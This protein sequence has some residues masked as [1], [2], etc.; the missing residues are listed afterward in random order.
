MQKKILLPLLFT[1]PALP[2]LAD[3]GLNA[4]AAG[5]W[6][7]DAANSDF[8][9]DENGNVNA[10]IANGLVSQTVSG[11]PYGN[12]K[13][14]L[15]GAINCKVEVTGSNVKMGE[16]GAFEI[17]GTSTDNTI[18]IQISSADKT[19]NFGFG[20]C[21]L[22]LVEDYSAYADEME[23]KLTS[24]ALE[25]VSANVAAKLPDTA[26]SLATQK[27]GVEK[28]LT[29]IEAI[30]D[31]LRTGFPADDTKIYEVSQLVQLYNDYI[32]NKGLEEK[33][34]GYETAVQDYND[35][36]KA[37]NALA[38]LIIDN[39]NAKAALLAEITDD[40]TPALDAFKTVVGES[41]IEYA[42]GR[43]N[44][45]I[46]AFETKLADYKTSIET[47]YADL[48]KEVTFA[49][50]KQALLDEIDEMQQNF[51]GD[52]ADWNALK[53]L[54]DLKQTVTYTYNK[55]SV[56]IQALSGLEGYENVYNDVKS[57]WLSTVAELLT[58]A[59]N[60]TTA[61]DE[62]A[63]PAGMAGTKGDA[64]KAI[65]DAAIA[66]MNDKG[67]EY[68]EIVKTQNDN[69]TA[70]QTEI[71]GYQ[72]RVEAAQ[73][74]VVPKALGEAG[75]E[76]AVEA[77]NDAV[78]ALST[79]VETEYKAH[80]LSPEAY[81]EKNVAAETAVKALED[82][83]ASY[84]DIIDLQK[85]L[86]K[87][88]SDL[89]PKMP[90]NLKTGFENEVKNLQDAIDALTPDST[91]AE[92]SAVGDSIDNLVTSYGGI[93]K[94]QEDLDA[95]KKVVAAYKEITIGD[96]T[97]SINDKFA[98]TVKNIQDAI[99]TVTPDT[100][101]SS[102]AD[103]TRAIKL[104]GD[105]AKAMYD[106]FTAIVGD[107]DTFIAE[108]N[109][110]KSEIGKPANFDKVDI[111]SFNK[112][113]V[114]TGVVDWGNF[115][116]K[117]R[118]LFVTPLLTNA[119]KTGA[120]DK[121]NDLKAA[122]AI[123]NPQDCY[124]AATKVEF[125]LTDAEADLTEVKMDFITT[126]V[127]CNDTY[128]SGNLD[129]A[130]TRY[131]DGVA[132]GV[133]GYSKQADKLATATKSLTDTRTAVN[134]ATTYDAYYTANKKY[135]DIQTSVDTFNTN[136]NTL[137]KSYENYQA[138]EKL[139]GDK[140][141]P[142]EG[143]VWKAI[144]QVKKDNENSVGKA[145]E[146]F[147]AVIAA[148][149]KELTDEIKTIEG[150]RDTA[151]TWS[152]DG[153]TMDAGITDALLDTYK[154]AL[155]AISAK[156]GDT[157]KAIILNNQYFSQQQTRSAAVRTAVQE[158]YNTIDALD[159][160]IAEVEVWLADV[161]KLVD[162]DL[163]AADQEVNKAYG[164]GKSYTDNPRLLALYD[165]IEA[166]AKKILADSDAEYAGL[167]IAWNDNYVNGELDEDGNIVRPSWTSVLNGLNATYTQAIT[168]YNNYL[169]RLHNEGYMAYLA[170]TLQANQSLYDYSNE[171]N[172]LVEDEAALVQRY[173]DAKKLLNTS[174]DWKDEILDPAAKLDE[175]IVAHEGALKTEVDQKAEEYYKQ[176]HD[177]VVDAI[178]DAE[179][180]MK[181]AGMTDEQ[182]ETALASDQQH[183]KDAVAG[184]AAATNIGMDMDNIA[185]DLDKVVRPIDL[186][187][188]A[189]AAW[190]SAYSAAIEKYDA[191]L[192]TAKGL[193]TV[194]YDADTFDTALQDMTDL[195]AEVAGVTTGLV[196]GLKG[197]TDRL[198]AILDALETYVNGLVQQDAN[199]VDLNKLID[200]TTADA[201][202]LLGTLNAFE[203][204][205]S[206]F[207]V[208]TDM[209]PYV[210]NVSAKLNTLNTLIGQ[211]DDSR[212]VAYW[213]GRVDAAKTAFNSALTTGYNML[214]GKELTTLATWVD[215][216]EE[217]YNNAV[218]TEGVTLPEYNDRINALN[219]TY[220]ALSVKWQDGTLD[221]NSQ[222]FYD[223]VE[224]AIADATSIYAEL[225]SK[226][227]GDVTAP[228]V[229]SVLADLNKQYDDIDGAISVAEANLE[230]Y[231]DS[232][233]EEYQ[234]K[235]DAKKAELD[236]I[237]AEYEAQGDKILANNANY[238]KKLTALETEVATLVADMEQAQVAAVA[239]QERIAASDARAAEL[240]TVIDE[241]E[242]R[243]TQV[244]AIAE[245]YGQLSRVQFY[246]DNFDTE[247]DATKAWLATES[248]N[249]T[250]TADTQLVNEVYLNTQLNTAEY[251]ATLYYAQGKRS[252]C[253]TALSAV[254]SALANP[255][256]IDKAGL[257]AEYLAL[258]VRR[259][260]VFLP[261]S[262]YSEDNLAAAKDAIEAYEAITADAA[263]LLDKVNEN[264]YTPGDVDLSGGPVNALD[265]Q[266]IIYWIGD[267]TE[268]G[269]ELYDEI[270]AKNPVQAYAADITGD[271]EINIADVTACIDLV[272]GL[273]HND[274]RM[275]AR[276]SLRGVTAVNGLSLVYVGEVDGAKRY[277]VMLDNAV[278]MNGAQ[279]DLTLPA[280]AS[281]V[282]VVRTERTEGHEVAVFNNGLST[283]VLLFS[284]G[285][286]EFT[287]NTGAI[288]FIDVE[289]SA[290][291]LG[292]AVFSDT[293]S[294]SIVVAPEGTTGIMDT[295]IDGANKAKEMIFDAAGRIYNKVQRG[296]NIIR[297]GNG[298]VTK[299]I[300]NNN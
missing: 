101:T 158:I 149:E 31:G 247:M 240:Q 153:K 56:D 104:L 29:D 273:N 91:D 95:A 253:G 15:N 171:I 150:T 232:V 258:D 193:K 76:D 127:S 214:R 145:K 11:L 26:K 173:N 223:D 190:A 118:D 225:S 270:L 68:A 78:A 61:L 234:P 300:R 67:A 217:S 238:S 179:A 292:T 144:E 87:A 161:Q 219:E 198:D 102:S 263:A 94:L 93:I 10:S 42:V 36:V 244:E 154:G 299:E 79:E 257:N 188:A 298:K 113:G 57:G 196:N 159:H 84:A 203:A 221:S 192:E 119:D 77:A 134:K 276:A 5:K 211:I 151:G 241:L 181:A 186:Q 215:N 3:V 242:T 23:A 55:V 246:L 148:I 48:Q 50:Q 228:T 260:N 222:E 82:L 229:E 73:V 289:G 255:Y 284:M 109:T 65:L 75:Y 264:I 121:L 204:Y 40:I 182:I 17:T 259:N 266:T 185:D 63:D 206:Q 169:Y 142:A 218:E 245:G 212:T 274:V 278:A 281:V 74:D 227:Q 71:S 136:L 180:T 268:T 103:I 34:S 66:A 54:Q 19:N 126:V 165:D 83:A 131:N 25:E 59:N 294:R 236:A 239:E 261:G 124:D 132:A 13:V 86:D 122:A 250:L 187:A 140:A 64:L 21:R 199:N 105:D 51:D 231:I 249:H 172:A 27:S 216:A 128:V 107:L 163:L 275:A 1:V 166:A 146:H 271:K 125:N 60:E 205:V 202:A 201:A 207:C 22:V 208:A 252:E 164:E 295:L 283:R 120:E 160:T 174:D 116:T 272:L 43:A 92:V 41:E 2:A 129:A 70:A 286:S 18:T 233:K 267:S 130:T 194:S 162:E 147:D 7:A 100:F 46:E 293:S 291:A 108:V 224:G 45:A 197:Y 297:H 237:K 33:I 226:W 16:D 53:S 47:A 262:Q 269:A 133:P 111:Y 52:V 248:A 137:D 6:T 288:L 210:N 123:E 99:N 279:I 178:A 139:V 117:Y 189:E 235:L 58:K 30:L 156:A 285:N 110:F 251:R 175:K 24:Q 157:S 191:L 62:P 28:Q 141:A 39:E 12:Y 280:S 106:A 135:K 32:V 209:T 168:T 85:K 177:A 287:G 14:E 49:S 112:N 35:A 115:K 89:S 254:N 98:P 277:A 152:K 114:S 282:S 243:R 96:T 143:T 155:D 290:P 80:E 38:Q 213:Q 183:L 220:L 167:V 20:S 69:M 176:E 37:A 9:Q 97:L 265:V 230:G 138:L 4:P 81:D 72:A 195:D 184:Y 256:I 200:D 90:S 170:G 44:T 8:S 88:N 296:I